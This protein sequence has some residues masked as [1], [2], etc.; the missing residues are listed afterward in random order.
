MM[1]NLVKILLLVALLTVLVIGVTWWS[2][3]DAMDSG[4][5]AV[6]SI[7]ISVGI[8][9]AYVGRLEKQNRKR[10]CELKRVLRCSRYH[11]EDE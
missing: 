3:E 11:T 5:V 8:L 1:V 6:V 4:V 2:M 7:I 9:I 10:E